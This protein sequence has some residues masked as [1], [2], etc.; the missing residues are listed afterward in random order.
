MLAGCDVDADDPASPCPGC[1]GGGGLAGTIAGVCAAPDQE[2][3]ADGGTPFCVD[4]A[5]DPENCGACGT[6]CVSGLDCIAGVC[7]VASAACP[8]GCPLGQSCIQG[9]CQAACA[10]PLTSCPQG[11]GSACVDLTTDVNNCGVCGNA[12]PPTGHCFAGFCQ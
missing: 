1:T 11:V 6:T 5:T 7:E 2:C 9:S 4:L 3:A 8:G 12:C 10:P